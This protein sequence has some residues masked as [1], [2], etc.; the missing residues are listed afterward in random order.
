[1]NEKF[2][3]QAKTA[4]SPRESYPFTAKERDAILRLEMNFDI[5]GRCI[6]DLRIR[7]EALESVVRVVMARIPWQYVTLT[8]EERALLEEFTP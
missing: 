6:N 4:H 5:I 7:T 8:E 3:L 2:M 1:M